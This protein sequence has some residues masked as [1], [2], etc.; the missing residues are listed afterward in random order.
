MKLNQR[1]FFRAALLAASLGVVAAS[2]TT[3]L[4]QSEWV[5]HSFDG[6]HGDQPMGNLIADSAG[7][8]YGTAFQGGAHNWGIVYELVRPVPPKTAWTEIV[9]YNFTGGADGAL[10]E[11]GVIFDNAGN[12]FGTTYQG[13]ASKTGTVFELSPPATPGGAWTE[14]V[15][16]SFQ[17]LSGDGEYP[18][19]GLTWDHSGN[20]IGVTPSGGSNRP[21]ACGGNCGTVFQLSPPSTT[22]GEW[23]ET[24]L[25]NF[26]WGQGVEPLG[27]PVV[28]ANGTLYGTTYSGG[29][30]GEG[31]VYR[32][33]PPAAPDG[34]WAYRVLHAFTAGLDGASPRGSLALH[35]KGVLYGTTT[36][37]GTNGGGTVFQLVPPVNPGGA[38]TEN[39]LYNFGSFT[40]DAGDPAANIIF[41]SAGNIYG[42][43]T[44][45]GT[46]NGGAVFQLTP[47]ASSDGNWTETVLHSF[48]DENEND[49]ALPSGG[50]IFGKNGVLFGVTQIGGAHGEGAVY[51]VTK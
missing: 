37:A 25:Q 43:T 51:G 19:T 21:S 47:P 34:S 4:A 44:A 26:K 9:L 39:I 6:T 35:G 27:I 16:H 14:S 13:G 38:W 18:E 1:L 28:A 20:L 46:A 17:P 5:V 32:L 22:G 23:T 40:G 7:N 49:G 33:T 12:L 3:S 41:D 15:L 31:V 30:G 10:P 24:I 29:L 2:S 42:T 8:L 45:G 50:L 48:H 11:G 36:R